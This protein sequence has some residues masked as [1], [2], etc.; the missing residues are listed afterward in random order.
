MR[1]KNGVSPITG[2]SL[3]TGVSP[4]TGVNPSIIVDESPEATISR[5]HADIGRLSI[6]SR[7]P[8]EN[9]KTEGSPEA[10]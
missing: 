8:V 7:I 6:F 3:I 10:R 5:I 2:V 4:F 9:G 1:P